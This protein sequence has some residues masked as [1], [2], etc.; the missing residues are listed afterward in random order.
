MALPNNNNNNKS[1]QRP[2]KGKKDTIS[3]AMERWLQEE[4]FDEPWKYFTR[5][6]PTLP[7]AGPAAAT[8]TNTS[9]KNTA[10]GTSKK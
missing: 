7:S 6:A 2:S 5:I 3:P 10:Q 4:P 9:S 8:S 1:Q